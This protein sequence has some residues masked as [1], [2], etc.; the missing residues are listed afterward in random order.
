MDITKNPLLLAVIA[1]A[2]VLLLSSFSGGPSQKPPTNNAQN[3]GGN[4]DF[5]DD[6]AGALGAA[7]AAGAPGTEWE[8]LRISATGNDLKRYVNPKTTLGGAILF[9]PLGAIPGLLGASAR[10]KEAKRVEKRVQDF[11]NG[12]LFK[13]GLQPEDY[14]KDG[15]VMRKKAGLQNVVNGQVKAKY[16]PAMINKVGRYIS[17]EDQQ[18]GNAKGGAKR[19]CKRYYVAARLVKKFLEDE[20]NEVQP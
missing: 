1:G 15:S 5:L 14:I 2:A 17:R 8:D 16:L 3:G 4:L 13:I 12:N 7:I 9:G 19:A 10:Q 20:L 6:A 18:C 11:V